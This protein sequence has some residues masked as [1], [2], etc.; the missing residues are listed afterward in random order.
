MFFFVVN[1]VWMLTVATIAAMGDINAR[2]DRDD[3]S[4]DAL[5][6]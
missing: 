5:I 6:D 2:D 3:C 1:L 4:D